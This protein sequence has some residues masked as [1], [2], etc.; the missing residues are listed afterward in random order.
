MLS[1]YFQNYKKRGKNTHVYPLSKIF[2]DRMTIINPP[3]PLIIKVVSA[4]SAFCKHPRTR[5]EVQRLFSLLYPGYNTTNQKESGTEGTIE[6]N[7]S[8]A[9]TFPPSGALLRSAAEHKNTFTSS[10]RG[11][12]RGNAPRVE[13]QCEN[14]SRGGEEGKRVGNRTVPPLELVNSAAAANTVVETDTA[15]FLSCFSSSIVS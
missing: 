14:Q 11:T 10:G 4:C 6:R 3:S 15:C 13:G 2:A 7:A 12:Y 9:D 5:P 1:F 8:L